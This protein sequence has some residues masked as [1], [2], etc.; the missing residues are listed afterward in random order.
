MKLSTAWLE[1][2]ETRSVSSPVCMYLLMVARE[3]IFVLSAPVPKALYVLR[4]GHVWFFCGLFFIMNVWCECWFLLPAYGFLVQS[5]SI[6]TGC[7]FIKTRCKA[8]PTDL[9]SLV[10]SWF[11]LRGIYLICAYSKQ[12]SLPVTGACFSTVDCPSC[13]YCVLEENR[14]RVLTATHEGQSCL[15][16]GWRRVERIYLPSWILSHLS[17]LHCRM[18]SCFEKTP[19]VMW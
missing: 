1:T 9:S 19:K 17:S 11:L 4:G 3:P 16:W 2:V 8:E 15:S 7:W 5:R 13:V 6:V 18:L 12:V 10:V 14:E